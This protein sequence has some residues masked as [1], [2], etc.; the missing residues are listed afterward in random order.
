MLL[1]TENHRTQGLR[2]WGE[3]EEAGEWI[4]SNETQDLSGEKGGSQ[5]GKSR[6]HGSGLSCVWLR[7]PGQRIREA[8][9]VCQPGWSRRCYGSGLRSLAKPSS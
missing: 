9:D 2:S 1:W 5:G 7:E 4:L 3:G 8:H 6:K